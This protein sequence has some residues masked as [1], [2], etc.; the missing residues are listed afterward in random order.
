[1]VFQTKKLS[2]ET[3]G[4]YL[5]AVRS[6]LGLSPV[7]VQERSGVPAALVKS[8]ESGSYQKLPA[9]V[10]VLGSLSQLAQAY[11]VEAN[12]L[13]EQYRRER[14]VHEQFERRKFSQSNYERAVKTALT[15]KSILLLGIGLLV[16]ATLGY[17]VYQVSSLSRTPPL[18]VTEPQDRQVIAGSVATVA[19][20]TDPT[21]NVT[22]N[23]QPV[24]V[25]PNGTF[26]VQ[27]SIGAG[28]KELTVEAKSRFGKSAVRSLTVVGQPTEAAQKHEGPA[29]LLLLSFTRSGE[30]SVSFDG[31]SPKTFRRDAGGEVVATATRE[32]LV[33]TPD[34]GAVSVTLNGKSM[35]P[36]GR[37]GE[38]LE[39][40]PFMAAATPAP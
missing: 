34:A 22:V 15:P 37:S 13:K 17:L 23:G 20:T 27:V 2:T 12:P 9:D 36:L 4:E 18:S 26:R 40:V 8:L 28:P 21:A 29:L 31:G 11:G 3:L 16:L 1:M 6:D 19:G 5:A 10:Y 7:D 32:L 35:G 24:L 30:V 38:R 39:Q 14:A 33:S 25:E